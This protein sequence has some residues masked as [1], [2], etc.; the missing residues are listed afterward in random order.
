MSKIS[1]L[2]HESLTYLW[3]LFSRLYDHKIDP[4]Q[5][6]LETLRYLGGSLLKFPTLKSSKKERILS[7]LKSGLSIQQIS[8]RYD[9]SRQYVY[10]LTS[11]SS[12]R[13]DFVNKR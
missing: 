13:S 12:R 10:S 5:A 2:N 6:K 8:E 1:S 4:S 9:V 7:A 11:S 3:D